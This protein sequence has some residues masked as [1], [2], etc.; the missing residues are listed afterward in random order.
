[1]AKLAKYVMEFLGILEI[2]PASLLIE[3]LTW[4]HIGQFCLKLQLRGSRLE[5]KDREMFNKICQHAKTSKTSFYYI[6]HDGQNITNKYFQ[7]YDWY[8]TYLPAN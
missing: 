7:A 3:K 5:N 8:D 1:M 4:D 6:L 2:L